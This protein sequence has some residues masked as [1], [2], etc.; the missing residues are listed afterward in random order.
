MRAGLGKASHF[1]PRLGL[2]YVSVVSIFIFAHESIE[3]KT[4]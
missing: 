2:G 3:C 4:C 1:L